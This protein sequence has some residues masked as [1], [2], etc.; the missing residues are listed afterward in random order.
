M[1]LSVAVKSYYDYQKQAIALSN[2]MKLKK[3]GTQQE[4]PENQKWVIS[5]SDMEFFNTVYENEKQQ[6]KEI[7]KYIHRK[8]KEYPVYTEF[9]VNVKGVGDLMSAVIV[10]QFDI[11]KATTVSKMWQFAGL[12]P[13]TVMGKKKKGDEIIITDTLVR[14]DRLT[15][16]FLS[17]F[18][19][20]LRTKLIGVLAGSFIKSQSPYALE[21]Y[22]PY[23]TRL[24]QSEKKIGDKMWSEESKGHRDN[25][26]KRYMVKMF[27]KDLYVA[28]RTLEG[29]EV[30]PS[31]QEEYLGHI[32]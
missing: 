19:Q 21:Y 1:S 31:Y 16:G 7:E 8:L 13:G 22:Y 32:H 17:P 25:A 14:G 2:R 3:D 30:R 18:N 26:A 12:N 24:E 28:W 11:N 15:P 23:K 9:L 20:W 6:M 29:L 4:I 5:K 10:D 27:I